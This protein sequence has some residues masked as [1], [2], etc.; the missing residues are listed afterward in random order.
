M[1]FK[2]IFV[3]YSFFLSGA[4]VLSGCG[5]GTEGS[6][7]HSADSA[8]IENAKEITT[9]DNRT[10]CVTL[11]SFKADS[12]FEAGFKAPGKST[13]TVFISDSAGS[14]INVTNDAV[15]TGISQYPMMFMNN[16]HKHS[17]PYKAADVTAA[18]YGVYNLDV[19]Y[20]MP[21]VKMDGTSTGRWEYR[22]MLT[23]NN[24][25]ADDTTDDKLHTLSFEPAVEMLMSSKVFR[26]IAKNESDTY[27]NAMGIT[28]PRRYSVWLESVAKVVSGEAVVKVY[29]TAE[30][31]QHSSMTMGKPTAR[32]A[33]H[34]HGDGGAM[35]DADSQT[36]PAVH[37]PMDMMGTIMKTILHDAVGTVADVATVSVKA[38]TD[39]GI[40]W[41]TLTAGMTHKELG[42]YSAPVPMTAGDVDMKIKVTVDGNVM[43]KTGA[44]ADGIETTAMPSLLFSA[45]E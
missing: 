34:V 15:I 41:T 16:G 8:C 6:H 37:A 25:T 44:A 29:L 43:T 26:A 33:E 36:Y 1:L 9:S 4:V 14:P 42:Y 22:V 12:P 40:T 21:S 18:E 2:K 5:L 45:T 19:Y 30:D 31:M 7:E 38:S 28:A 10:L 11:T 27:K 32:E 35:G 3:L 13:Q 17:A 24:G 23:D 39:N 20:P